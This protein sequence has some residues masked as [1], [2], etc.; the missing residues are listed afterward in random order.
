MTAPA[1]ARCTPNQRAKS[2]IAA[3]TPSIPVSASNWYWSEKTSS[4]PA[5]PPDAV[6]GIPAGDL[7]VAF[8]SDSATPPNPDKETF[9]DL[10]LSSVPPDADVTSLVVTVHVD[11]S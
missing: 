8:T 2:G 5:N 7:A 1:A 3:A 9:L 4:N 11:Q 10:D 6:S